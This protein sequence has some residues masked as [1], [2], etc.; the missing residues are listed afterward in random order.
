MKQ[1]TFLKVYLVVFTIMALLTAGLAYLAYRTVAYGDD[2]E[3][4]V[5][6]YGF[7]EHKLW[8]FNIIQYALLTLMAAAQHLRVGNRLYYLPTLFLFIVIANVQ[9]MLLY[10]RYYQFRK[11]NDI[12]DGGF[13]AGFLIGIFQSLLVILA[14]GVLMLG[15]TIVRRKWKK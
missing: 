13:D 5:V 10:S 7:Y 8:Q 9:Y 11:V 6:D 2:L 15:G 14:T 12:L 4:V 3:R 1:P